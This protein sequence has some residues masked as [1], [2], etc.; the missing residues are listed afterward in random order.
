MGREVLERG[1]DSGLGQ[2]PGMGGE[3]LYL[4]VWSLKV[5]TINS[6]ALNSSCRPMSFLT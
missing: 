3:A 1:W 5:G 6:R 2:M 4:N